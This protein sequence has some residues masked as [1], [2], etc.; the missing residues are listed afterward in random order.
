M[1]QKSA[2]FFAK[3]LITSRLRSL[4]PETVYLAIDFG[5]DVGDAREICTR[6]IQSRLGRSLANAELGDA[7][8]FLD[9][10][11]AIHR[12]RRKNLANAPLFDN[13]VV[14]TRQT[15]P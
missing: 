2:K 9:Y 4:T 1:T 3:H 15:G 11:A 12:F 8:S 10:R 14:P 6:R 13:R 7:G 5:N